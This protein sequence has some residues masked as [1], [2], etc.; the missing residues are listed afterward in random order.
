MHISQEPHGYW[1]E[2]WNVDWWRWRR[3]CWDWSKHILI[4]GWCC[5]TIRR[6]WCWRRSITRKHW[7]LE[8]LIFF[9]VTLLSTGE[10]IVI[11]RS[12]V[13]DRVAIVHIQDWI[14]NVTAVISFFCYLHNW[15]FTWWIQK[16]CNIKQD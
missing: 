5:W 1:Q 10:I 13:E 15:I 4:R 6:C 14:C 8:F 9:T 3:R 12:N 2:D 16:N 11:K 7:N